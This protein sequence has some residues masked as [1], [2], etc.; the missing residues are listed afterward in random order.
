MENWNIESKK[1]YYI[2]TIDFIQSLIDD[3]EF[4]KSYGGTVEELK[5]TL[6]DLQNKLNELLK[7]GL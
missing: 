6:L 4:L 1:K 7:D 2:K 3:E 5:D